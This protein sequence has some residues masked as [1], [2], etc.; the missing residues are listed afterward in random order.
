[1]LRALAG[2][3]HVEVVAPVGYED[4]V[5]AQ[6]LESETGVKVHRLPAI[7]PATSP[8]TKL[9]HWARRHS[10]VVWRRWSKTAVEQAH[11]LVRYGGEQLT[12]V[13]GTFAAPLLPD[14]FDG[15]L[16]LGLHNVEAEVV[17]RLNATARGVRAMPGRIEARL[18]AALEKRLMDRA[19]L[20]VVV[21]ERDR[22]LVQAASPGA[23]AEVVENTVDVAAMPRLGPVP[24]GPPTLLFVGS[25]DYPPNREA[26]VEIF[27][28]HAPELRRS[29][30]EL[31]FRLVGRDSTGVIASRAQAV[32]GVE[33]VGFVDDL[34]EEY[35][36]AHAVYV[37][38]RSGGGTRIKVLEAFAYGRPVIATELAIE[39]L[40]LAEGTH[41]LSCET[42]G[43]GADSIRQVL[44]GEASSLVDAGRRLV[45]D[46]YSH[47]AASVRWVELAKSARE[48]S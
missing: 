22:D 15:R 9:G 44:A 4:E 29:I 28:V 35:E 23:R 1:M 41:Y 31:R 12:I 43:R 3:A 24:D 34:R 36:R 13:D 11:E 2:H 17:A 14:G 40:G 19:T 21:S 27:D 32:E 39:G 46:R 10:D 5:H 16:I 8:F 30:P 38:L 18:V 42:A 47:G 37:P 26:A 25:F 45:E 48:S 33:M 7:A 6:A 20:T